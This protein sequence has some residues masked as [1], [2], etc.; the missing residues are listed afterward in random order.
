M[1]VENKNEVAEIDSKTNQVLARWP[2]ATGKGP[3]GLAIDVDAI[4]CLP[5]AGIR[6]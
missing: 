5:D 3:T 2:L 6:R 4:G 1:N